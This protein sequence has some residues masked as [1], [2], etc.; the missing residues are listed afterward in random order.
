MEIILDAFLGDSKKN[1]LMHAFD[2]FESFKQLAAH[3]Q[4]KIEIE[5]EAD[6]YTL[7]E[8]IKNQLKSGEINVVFLSV[9]LIDGQINNKI[10]PYIQPGT[11]AISDG[12]KWGLF[13]DMLKKLDY[14]VETDENMRVTNAYLDKFWD[15]FNLPLYKEFLKV[16]LPQQ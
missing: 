10:P 15:T 9:R 2:A 3:S 8:K 1:H 12:K 4:F 14:K 6:L 7:T 5:D 11:S 16:R 13:S